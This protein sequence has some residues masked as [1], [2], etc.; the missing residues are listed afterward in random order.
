MEKVKFNIKF[1]DKVGGVMYIPS[2]EFV[3]VPKHVI[4]RLKQREKEFKVKNEYEYDEP[5]STKKPT[6]SKLSD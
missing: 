4:Y 5:K 2:T 3:E 1:Y 6:K